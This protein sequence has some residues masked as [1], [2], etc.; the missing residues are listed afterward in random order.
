M[1]KQGSLVSGEPWCRVDPTGDTGAN[2]LMEFLFTHIEDLRQAI[3]WELFKDLWAERKS[4][5]DFYKLCQASNGAEHD[6]FIQGW[7]WCAVLSEDFAEA[8]EEFLNLCAGFF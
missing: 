2:D 5:E 6:I 3:D 1:T 4:A 7:Q 8:K